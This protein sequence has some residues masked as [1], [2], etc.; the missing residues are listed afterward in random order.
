MD[1]VD[2]VSK[3]RSFMRRIARADQR[4]E[5][6]RQRAADLLREMD[7]LPSVGVAR[8]GDGGGGHG[9]HHSQVEALASKRERM[10]NQ[11]A[12]LLKDAEDVLAERAEVAALLARLNW[13]ILEREKINVIKARYLH[14]MKWE[15]VARHE[16]LPASRCKKDE[17]EGLLSLA[18]LMWGLRADDCHYDE[19]G[20]YRMTN[21]Q[22]QKMWERWT[23]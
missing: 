16:H 21:E 6:L 10:E 23:R 20:L 12:A 19:E 17:R 18:S 22:R 8:P 13:N 1:A 7:F 5:E 9:G 3:T 15:Q 2:V 11:R 14:G 4:A